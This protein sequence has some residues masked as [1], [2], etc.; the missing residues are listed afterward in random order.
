VATPRFTDYKKVHCASFSFKPEG[1]YHCPECYEFSVD[2]NCHAQASFI[3]LIGGIKE[4]TL[5][6][7]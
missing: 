5:A 3:L 1:M 7:M 2:I 6:V 4:T